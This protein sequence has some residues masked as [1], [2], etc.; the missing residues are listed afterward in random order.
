MR[1]ID[2]YLFRQLLGPTIWAIA[3]LAGVGVLSQSLSGLELIVNQG[4]SVWV[5]LK[6]TALAM[7]QM[8][9]LIVPL[10]LFVAALMTL[11][12]LH[13]EQEIIVCY[14][15]GMSRWRVVSPGFRLALWIT[16]ITL[17]VNLWIEPLASR[18]MRETLNAA[19]TDLAAALVHEGEFTQ[20]SPGLT[21]YAQG[22]ERGGILKNLFVHTEGEHQRD[23]TYTAA[24]GRLTKR[25]GQP[26]LVME[27]GA[28]QAFDNNGQ[29]SYLAFEENVFDL[30]PFVKVNTLPSTKAADRY[31]SELWNP[32]PEDA[33]GQQNR[34]V[35]RAEFHNRLAAPLYN[36]TFMAFAVFALLGDRF[37]RL[38]YAR[39]VAMMSVA[40]VMLRIAGFVVQDGASAAPALNILQYVIPIFGIAVTMGPFLLWR[41]YL[42]PHGA[43]AARAA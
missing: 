36:L 43:A 41:N 17:A 32:A 31:M 37:S 14:A 34:Q 27:N 11:N 42:R 33:W 25:N 39:R 16:L 2:R 21:V 38:G 3:A 20:P 12:R 24:T 40:A 22:V 18:N 13:A 9:V 30:S 15:G 23:I 35:L 1:L 8:L 28:T 7:P 10:A 4:Q 29:L 6:V 5:F 26:V 19:R